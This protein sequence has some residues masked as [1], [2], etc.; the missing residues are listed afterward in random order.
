M[1]RPRST[2]TQ[3]HASSD[4]HP[5]G[6]HARECVAAIALGANLGD[7]AAALRFAV[8][9]LDGAP[10]LHVE[11]RG[12]IIETAPV[13]P[14]NQPAYLNSAVV[15]RTTLS[16][17]SLLD[18]LLMIEQE[19]GRNRRADERWG[20]RVLDLDLLL[21]ADTVIDEPGLTVPHPRLH[22]RLFVLDP[23]AAI[24]GEWMH[25]GFE[26]TIADLCASVRAEAGMLDE[27]DASNDTAP[28]ESPSPSCNER[29]VQLDGKPCQ[30]NCGKA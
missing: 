22:E 2:P 4:G 1:E 27:A 8:H 15:V 25:P 18:V 20:P 9:R 6:D 10:S 19:A 29:S 5:D 12:P 7:R 21:Y 28:R 13:G 14:A 11:R 16:P 3:Q 24:A 26:R 17:R 30:S 23:L